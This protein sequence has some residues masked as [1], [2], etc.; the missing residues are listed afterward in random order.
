MDWNITNCNLHFWIGSLPMRS[1]PRFRITVPQKPRPLSRDLQDTG[2]VIVS[3]RA[4][5]RRSSCLHPAEQHV[6]C[7]GAQS[8]KQKEG[9]RQNSG[10][11]G[12]RPSPRSSMCLLPRGFTASRAP[13]GASVS[14]R[15]AS[16][17]CSL[18]MPQQQQQ[19]WHGSSS[20][21]SPS[22]SLTVA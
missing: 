2:N 3:W 7:E 22:Y 21:G 18:G 8:Y 10:G 14:R 13:R 6:P 20:A 19:Q 15:T 12:I 11:G 16:A 17:S 5:P 1:I 9:Q 4:K